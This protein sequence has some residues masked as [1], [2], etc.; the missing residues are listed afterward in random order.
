[1]LP[2]LKYF[3][4]NYSC[5]NTLCLLNKMPIKNVASQEYMKI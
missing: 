1:M 3:K 2:M 5:L 4:V